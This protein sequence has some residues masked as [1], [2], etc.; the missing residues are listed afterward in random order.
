[1]LY[2]AV[3][4]TE[5][6]LPRDVIKNPDQKCTIYDTSDID[7]VHETFLKYNDILPDNIT[8]SRSFR[9]FYLRAIIDF[10]LKENGFIPSASPRC[11]KAMQEVNRIYYAT[12]QTRSCVCAPVRF[13]E[14]QQKENV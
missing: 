2:E 3:M 8:N 12:P 7:F 9:L 5:T 1:M 10:E 13:E 4:K 11:V 14:E 6:A